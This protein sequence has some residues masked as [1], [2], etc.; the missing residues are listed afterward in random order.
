MRGRC[1]FTE[2]CSLRDCYESALDTNGHVELNPRFGT[3]H[4]QLCPHPVE[5]AATALPVERNRCVHSSVQTVQCSAWIPLLLRLHRQVRASHQ[6]A[7]SAHRARGP[8]PSQRCQI[9][10]APSVDGLCPILGF[11]HEKHTVTKPFVMFLK[12]CRVRRQNMNEFFVCIR[13]IV[14]QIDLVWVLLIRLHHLLRNDS[15]RT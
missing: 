9:Y 1:T 4:K 13:V 10:V 12:P 14:C 7:L 2:A 6:T 15:S 11:S 3:T 8:P 5:C